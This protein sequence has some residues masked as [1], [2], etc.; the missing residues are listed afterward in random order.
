MSEDKVIRQICYTIAVFPLNRQKLKNLRYIFSRNVFLLT[1]G[2]IAIVVALL[3]IFGDTQSAIFLGLILA[4]NMTLGLAQDIRAWLALE[5]LQ[6]LTAPR[7][8]RVEPDLS[9]R[10]ILTDDIR[11]GDHI[12]LRNGDQI[13]CDG[14]LVETEGLELNEGLITGES[15][16]LPRAV[17]DHVLAGSIITSGTGVMRVETVFKES[18]I[19]RMT[20]G[21]KSYAVSESPIQHAVG[22]AITYSG[23]LLVIIILYVAAQ[24]ALTG[25]PHVRVVKEIGALAST[26]VPQGLAFAMTLLFAYGAAHL[27]R[28]N[29]LL[30]EVSATEKLGRIKN[31]CMDKTGTLTENMLVVEKMETPDG[32]N[33]E[34]AKLMTAAYILGSKDSSQTIEAIKVFTNLPYAGKIVDALSFSSWRPHGAV[35]LEEAEKKVVILAGAPEYFLPHVHDEVGHAWLTRLINTEAGEGK[36]VFCVVRCSGEHIPKDLDDCELSPI[37]V[38]VFSVKLRPGIREAIDFFQKRGVRIRIISGDHPDTVRA[39]AASAGI[40]LCEY[41]ITGS[42]MDGWTAEDYRIR[43]GE[44]TIFA[45]T[46]PEQKEQ[47]IESL[48]H[49]AFTAMVGDGANDA[50]AIKKADLG[51]AMWEGA[52]ATRQVAS[53]VLMNNSF[54]ALPG[55]VELADSIIKNAELFASIFFDFAFVG[56]FLFLMVS[57]SGYPYPLSPLNITLINYFAIGIPGILVSYWTIRPEHKIVVP[58]TRGIFAKVLPFTISSA[59]LQSVAIG[60]IFFL[61]PEATRATGTNLFVLLSSIIVGSIFFLFTPRVYRGTLTVLQMRQLWVLIAGEIMLLAAIF[62]IPPLVR[63]FDIHGELPS[64]TSLPK[65]GVILL[66]YAVLQYFLARLFGA[67]E[68]APHPS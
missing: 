21:I 2:I 31:L 57:I 9:E 27:F 30:Q 20:A 56:F 7:V 22:L 19:A 63:F 66:A 23:Y 51:I 67:K 64:L 55:G 15:T 38:F 11:K 46:L 40:A 34:E 6:L 13:P 17:N 10:D 52:P 44:Y 5:N 60:L 37:A 1:N 48:K 8:T 50:L 4:V 53:V 68:K 29:V 12:K 45:R 42:E 14:M 43:A 41:V 62:N 54:T 39:V 61:S 49:D 35:L 36:R 33:Q 28:R 65:L 47:I 25:E 24:G 58:D 3:Y 18:R 59:I 16:S 32:A 26:I